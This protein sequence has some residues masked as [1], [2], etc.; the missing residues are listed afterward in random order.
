MLKAV[1]ILGFLAMVG[2]LIGL[3]MTQS[4]FSPSPLVWIPQIG[5]MLLMVWARVTFGRRSFHFAA[6]PTAGG[7]VTEGPYRHVRHPIYS[8]VC[9]FAVAGTAAHGSWTAITLCGLVLAG[10]L[11]RL[12]CEEVLLAVRYPDYVSYAAKTKRLIPYVF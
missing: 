3:I 9:L 4:L 11:V 6:N 8:G 2:G 12:R 5:G 7:L 10:S 1:S